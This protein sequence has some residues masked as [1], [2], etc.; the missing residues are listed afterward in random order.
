MVDKQ[1]I[2]KNKSG[3]KVKTEKKI[4]VVAA[5]VLLVALLSTVMAQVVTKNEPV[6][7][8]DIIER[9]NTA[10]LRDGTHDD[11]LKT[12]AK[13][14][15]LREGYKRDPTCV[16]IAYKYYAYQGYDYEKATQLI[17]TMKSLVEKGRQVNS[18]L[19]GSETVE[20]MEA[21]FDGVDP[22][23]NYEVDED[24]FVL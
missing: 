12:I 5:A 4:V 8:Q 24:E 15:E 16:M 2:A 23:D 9:Y 13:E 22:N 20:Q 17:A 7:G 1:K 3:K 6:C 19:S 21:H 14:V 18:E 10:Y 11:E